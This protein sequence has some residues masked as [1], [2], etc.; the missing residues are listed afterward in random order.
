MRYSVHWLR[1]TK[2]YKMRAR[3]PA[4]A[5]KARLLLAETN[6][7]VR[8]PWT[9]VPIIS[10]YKRPRQVTNVYRPKFENIV[11]FHEQG[12]DHNCYRLSKG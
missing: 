1:K 3:G 12:G 9:N 7:T 5:P 6:V 4:P 8:T 11:T 10:F 2:T